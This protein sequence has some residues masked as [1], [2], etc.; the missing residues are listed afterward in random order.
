MSSTFRSD[1]KII[2]IGSS[3]AG[4]TSLVNK[5][6]KNIFDEVYRATILAEFGCKIFENEGKFYRIQL[7]DLLGQDTNAMVTKIFA[8]DSHGCVVMSDDTNIETRKE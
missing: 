3:G 2:V 4:K 5:W 7:W 1:F 8:K 6:T